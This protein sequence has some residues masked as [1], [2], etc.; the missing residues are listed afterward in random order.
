MEM[1]LQNKAK[2]IENYFNEILPNACC[3]LNY[4]KDYGFLIAVM[5]SAQ[6]T[7]KKVNGVTSVL[8]KKFDT[9]EK[10][11]QASIIELEDI[12]KPLG[13][14]KAKAK[15]VKQIAHD[16][17]YKFNKKVPTSKK[18]LMTLS[19]VGNK[20]SN[21]VRI[22]LFKIPE[23]PVDTHV[24]RVSKRLDLIEGNANVLDCENTLKSIFPKEHWILLH[25]QFIHF[26]RYYC[27]AINPK[28]DNCK[29]KGFC[30]YSKK[31]L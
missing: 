26:G 11:E 2:I 3:E 7:D 27:K 17:I 12:L 30:N 25:H 24:F 10:L 8:F 28:C 9:L 29:L 21:V 16:L 22:E 6:C 4:T 31:E 23:F 15:H 18:D 5:L 1:T 13:L 19:G 20:T 14:Y